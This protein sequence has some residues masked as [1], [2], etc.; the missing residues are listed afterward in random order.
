MA[1][2]KKKERALPG[3]PLGTMFDVTCTGTT[4]LGMH[5]NRLAVKT[6]P[7]TRALSLAIKEGKKKDADVDISAERVAHCEFRG[8]I[9]HDEKLGPYVPCTWVEANIQE[10]AKLT[11]QGMTVERGLSVIQN[12]IP[13]EYTGVRDVEELYE[14]DYYDIR[15]VN[16]DPSKGRK[17]PRGPRCRPLF[18]TWKI[19]YTVRLLPG[20]ID[21]ADVVAFIRDGGAYLGIGD[22]RSKPKW[23]RFEVTKVSGN[24]KAEEVWEKTCKPY[25]INYEAAR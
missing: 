20:M 4:P 23:G 5:N 19:S 3:S 16:L 2:A 25:L 11:R 21:P 1:T 17:G 8:G 24:A 12:R 10:A 22:G 15:I 9:Y 18:P 6:D 14:A 7:F 13:I